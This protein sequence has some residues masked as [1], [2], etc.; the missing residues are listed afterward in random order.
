[1]ILSDEKMEKSNLYIGK[2]ELSKLIPA[3]VLRL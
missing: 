2:T 1:M 3:R